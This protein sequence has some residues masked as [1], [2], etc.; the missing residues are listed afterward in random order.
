MNADVRDCAAT[1]ISTREFC[2]DERQ[3]LKDWQADYRKLSSVEIAAVWAIVNGTWADFQKQ[4][5][6]SFPISPEE[7][8]TIT[9]IMESAP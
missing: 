2:G 8:A 7:R 3:A 6:V 5:G 1:I 4:A 9:R